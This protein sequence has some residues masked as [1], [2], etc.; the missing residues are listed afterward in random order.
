MVRTKPSLWINQ[1]KQTHSPFA[2]RQTILFATYRWHK[3][4]SWSK[5]NALAWL[6]ESDD[7]ADSTKMTMTHENYLKAFET[8]KFSAIS[9]FSTKFPPADLIVEMALI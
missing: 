6:R 1:Q 4:H 5:P 7:A 9:K 3:P 2:A 8:R